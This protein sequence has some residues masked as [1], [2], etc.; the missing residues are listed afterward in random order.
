[1][2]KTKGVAAF[3]PTTSTVAAGMVLKMIGRKPPRE[4]KK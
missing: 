2:S 3:E 1:L 4:K